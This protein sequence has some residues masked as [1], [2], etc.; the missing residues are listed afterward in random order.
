MVIVDTNR[1]HNHTVILFHNLLP[2]IPWPG[3]LSSLS[4][5]LIHKLRETEKLIALDGPKS[6]YMW[7]SAQNA[8]TCLFSTVLLGTLFSEGTLCE[9]PH[10]ISWSLGAHTVCPLTEESPREI[11]EG[12]KQKRQH[13][14][15][16]K[17][18]CCLKGI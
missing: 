12:V 9:W 14:T 1:N 13:E 7:E 15:K 10:L 18:C 3:D 5:A 11:S 4:Q 17:H 16:K 6:V 8:M 2:L